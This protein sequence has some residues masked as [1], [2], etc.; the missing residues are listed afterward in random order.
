MLVRPIAIAKKVF[1]PV[2][3]FTGEQFIA[4]L[5]LLPTSHVEEYAK[6]LSIV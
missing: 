2:A 5:G 1:H 3:H 6:H 4:L